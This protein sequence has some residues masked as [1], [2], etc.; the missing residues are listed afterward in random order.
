MHIKASQVF[1]AL[2]IAVASIA[3]TGCVTSPSSPST[4]TLKVQPAGSVEVDPERMR[5]HVTAL[6]GTSRPRNAA[7]PLSLDQAAAYI[8]R[9]LTGMGYTLYEQRFQVEGQAYKNLIVRYGPVSAPRVV[10]G[11]HYDVAGQGPGADDNASG[12]AGLIE[13]ARLVSQQKPN[14]GYQIEFVAYT[15]EE[16]PHFGNATMG[17][18]VHAKA[19]KQEN[20]RVRLMMSLEMIGFY[21]DAPNSQHLPPAFLRSGSFSSTGNFIAVV[22]RKGSNDP[23]GMVAQAMRLGSD[24]PVEAVAAPMVMGAGLSDQLNY[25]NEGYVGL[26][27]TDT[28]FYRNPNYH[29]P[30]DV[31]DTLNY[32]KMAEVVE[33]LYYALLAL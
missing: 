20:A 30:T 8:G 13:L 14:L 31:P 5:N 1:A 23:V 3:V 25:W 18:A 11:A 24:I 21:S 26:M 27:I 9:E 28:S 15:L 17:S 19:L 12:V 29:K 10:I 6:I 16:P 7:N 4:L 2:A 32:T 22:G 33:G